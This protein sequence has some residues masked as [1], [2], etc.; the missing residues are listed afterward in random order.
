M[1]I[2]PV[3]SILYQVFIDSASVN[4]HLAYGA[5]VPISAFINI[6][7]T[8]GKSLFFCFLSVRHVYFVFFLPLSGTR[9]QLTLWAAA[10]REACPKWA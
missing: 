9:K 3:D 10:S 1:H 2:Y 6:G 7:Q 5:P 8:N 4:E